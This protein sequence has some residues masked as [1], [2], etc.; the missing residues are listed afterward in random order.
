MRKTKFTNIDQ[1][2]S[3]D[4]QRFTEKFH[5]CKQTDKGCILWNKNMFNY[6]MFSLQKHDSIPAHR[7]SYLLFN[8][9]CES[10]HVIRHKCDVPGCVNP[11]HLEKGTDQDNA[12]D[13][14]ERNFIQYAPE[15]LTQK[16]I[17]KI[18]IFKEQNL[19]DEDILLEL[20]NY[21][22]APSYWYQFLL[23]AI[24]IKIFGPIKTKQEKKEVSYDHRI[25]LYLEPDLVHFLKREAKK[26]NLSLSAYGRNLLTATKQI[27]EEEEKTNN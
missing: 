8:G 25:N 26:A 6:G 23:D 1:I 18:I 12:N 3:K 4:I 10:N 5:S 9:S 27:I 19:S 24:N 14:K 13:C 20:S 22:N 2:C 16:V 21:K 15:K 7:I 17:S 11:K